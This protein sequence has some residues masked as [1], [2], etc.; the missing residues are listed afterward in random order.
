[1]IRRPPRSTLF[2]YTTLFRSEATILS[3]E[4]RSGS[5]GDGIAGHANRTID[6]RVGRFGRKAAV[7]ALFD[8]NAGAFPLEMGVTTPLSPLEETING[9]PVLPDTDQIGR[10]HV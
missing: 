6:G 4:R 9:I 2:P 3:H 8:F 10:A 5:K 7:A 1:M